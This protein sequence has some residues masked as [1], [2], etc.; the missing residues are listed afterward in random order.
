MASK[1]PE[2]DKGKNGPCVWEKSPTPNLV[3]YRGGTYYLRARF[4]G[5]AIRESLGTDNYRIAKVKL[6]ERM[7]ELRDSIGRRNE[8]PETVLDALRLI[9]RRVELDPSIKEKSRRTY[10]EEF[11]CMESGKK[12]A[13]PAERLSRLTADHLSEW[14]ARVAKIYAPQRANHLLMFVRR[15][16]NE[17]RK[18][19][20]VRGD[21]FERIRPV[22][23]PRTRLKVVTPEQFRDLIMSIR[24]QR[25]AY[26]EEAANWIEFMSYSG[27][28]PGEIVALKWEDINDEQGVIRVFGGD[29]GTKNRQFRTVPMIPPMR[30]LI[31]RMRAEKSRSPGDKLFR[32]GPP[33]DALQSA[34]D[35]IGIP[36]MRIYDCRHYFAS[37]CNA[38]GVPVSTFSTWLGHRDGGTLA[39][40]TYVHQLDQQQHD[41]AAKVTF[42]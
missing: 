41:Q 12:A 2:T 30:E 4:G 14:W 15:A 6:A 42:K 24:S 29:Q 39:L 36:R 23:I 1:H 21:P 31:R 3:R 13:V 40:R 18:F 22:K 16:V 19:G 28:R 32:I 9:R 34:C 10:M 11:S 26:S 25:K 38:S 35:R 5:E 7:R 17:A 37:Q 33:G 20:V 27:M 8:A